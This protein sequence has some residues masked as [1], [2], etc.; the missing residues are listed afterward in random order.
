MYSPAL[1]NSWLAVCNGREQLKAGS[2]RHILQSSLTDPFSLP[3]SERGVGA[4]QPVFTSVCVSAHKLTA[5]PTSNL[6]GF[7]ED[8]STCTLSPT[9]G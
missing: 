9:L 5:P 7:N 3:G 6:N 8:D 2:C 1:Y 4:D